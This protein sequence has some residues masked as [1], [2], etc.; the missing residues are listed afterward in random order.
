MKRL[1]CILGSVT[2]AAAAVGV[3]GIH[4]G[5]I[6]APRTDLIE[7]TRSAVVATTM[8]DPRSP[9]VGRRGRKRRLEDI[10][11]QIEL[12]SG[13]TY[14]GDVLLE[15]DSS[16]ARWPERVNDPLRIWIKPDPSLEGWDPGFIDQVRAAFATWAEVDMPVRFKF[17][18][19]STDAEVHVNWVTR[20]NEPIS[21]KTRWARDGRW[22]IVDGNI[23]I[24]LHH[25]TG[26]L[27]SAA[28]IHAIALHEIGHLLGLDHSKDP[29]D[30][31]TPRVRVR[32]LS[33]ADRATMRLLYSL[34]PG[35]VR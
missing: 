24:A 10:R 5:R 25:N 22:W 26:P 33:D 27:L 13:G 29:G 16:L 34:P 32:T 18:E 2:A 14:I 11:R 35:A 21:G 7:I 31:M 6:P 17:V 20:F 30:I 3:W 8:D 15:H 28:A 23:T 19:D 9:A 1:Y 4:A 12:G